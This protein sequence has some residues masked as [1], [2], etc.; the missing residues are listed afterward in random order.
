M[1]TVLICLLCL[2]LTGC[3]FFTPRMDSAG[4]PIPGSSPAEQVG[5]TAAKSSNPMVSG[6]GW[7]LLL[8][9][10]VYGTKQAR[11]RRKA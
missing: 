9:A 1:R 11:G 10:G 5:N 8:G 3:W 7:L 6:L 4:N 2:M